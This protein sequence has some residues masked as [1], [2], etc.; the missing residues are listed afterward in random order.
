METIRLPEEELAEMKEFYQDEYEQATRRLA[1]IVSIMKRLGIDV[2]DTGTGQ[3]TA[4][5]KTRGQTVGRKVVPVRKRKKS[6]RRSKWELLIMKRLRQLDKPVTYDE[7]TDEIMAFSKLTPEKRT[8]TK[9][10]VINVI[11]RLRN[12]DKKLDTFSIGTRE[13]Y[14]AL[15][16]WFAAPGEIKKEYAAKIKSAKPASKKVKR[17]VGRPRKKTTE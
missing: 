1:H 15:K 13:K 16:N 14:I 12:R 17:K 6:A 8:S 10:S 4:V 11:F 5:A 9:Q 3:L 2:P 7:L